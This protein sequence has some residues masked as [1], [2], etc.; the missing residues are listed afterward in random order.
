MKKLY[1][2]KKNSIFTGILGGIGEYYDIDP[3]VV[4]VVF[5]FTLFLTGGIPMLLAY[6]LALF[7]VPE[8]PE[9]ET[10]RDAE[11]VT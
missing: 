3:V 8:P 1:R 2:S 4:R 11:I 6:F 5:L 9:G 10:I 7:V